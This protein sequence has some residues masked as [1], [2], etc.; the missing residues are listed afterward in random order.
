MAERFDEKYSFYSQDNFDT[1]VVKDIG[2]NGKNC[3][4]ILL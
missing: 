2:K 1:Y 3:D 4:F